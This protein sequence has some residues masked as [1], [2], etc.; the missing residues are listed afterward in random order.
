MWTSG[1]CGIGD[2]TLKPL[3]GGFVLYHEI[4]PRALNA[5]RVPVF[6]IDEA[7]KQQTL[8]MLSG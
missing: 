1:G 8:V 3:F 7:I 4:I 6:I 2:D 5:N